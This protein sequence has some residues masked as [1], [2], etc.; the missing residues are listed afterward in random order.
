VETILGSIKQ[1][2]DFRRF[3]RRGKEKADLESTLLSINYNLKRRFN[4]GGESGLLVRGDRGDG[5]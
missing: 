1:A 2:I 4:L 5:V 3:M